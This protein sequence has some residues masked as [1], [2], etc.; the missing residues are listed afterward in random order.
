MLTR[1]WLVLALAIPAAAQFRGG[2]RP[3]LPATVRAHGEGVAS[4]RPDQA[5]IDIGV[6]TE[7]ATA[8]AAAQQNA[9]QLSDALA[10]LKKMLPPGATVETINYSVNP[11][12]RYPRDGGKPT[13][14]GYTATN[15][16]RVTLDDLTAVGKVIDTATKT[17]ANTVNRVHFRLKD[18]QKVRA[19]ALAQATAMARANAEAMAKAAGLK[20][21]GIVVLEDTAPAVV[22]P[23]MQEMA[24]ARAADAAPTPVEPGV[25][26]VRATVTL[27]MAI[28]GQG[29]QR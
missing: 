28:E 21:G 22:R 16:V 18:E 19:Q 10:E 9:K 13:I 5:Q 27:W 11:N 1:A 17:G 29:S 2:E 3:A 14:A 26:E 8:Q 6:V 25:I 12:Y 23:V 7:A 4:A 20:L 24:M 15:T